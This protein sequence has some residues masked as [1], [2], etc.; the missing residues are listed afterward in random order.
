MPSANKKGGDME[1]DRRKIKILQAI[2]TDYINTGEPVGSRTI[3]KKYDL[4]ISSA[5]IRNE[6]S[7]LEEMGY[8]EQLHSSSGR[9]PSDKGYRLYVDKIMKHHDLTNEEEYIIKTKILDSALFEMDRLLRQATVLVSD[10]TRLTCIVNPPSAR[11]SSIRS[12]QLVNIDDNKMIFI[13]ITNNGIIKN[14]IIKTNSEIDYPTLTRL[15]NILNFRLRNL[16][17]DQMNLEVI[18]NLKTDLLDHEDIFNVVIPVLYESLNKADS[19]EAYAEGAQNIFNY[20]EYNDIDRAREFLTLLG[21]KDKLKELL[22]SSSSISIRIGNENYIDGAKD[23]SVITAVYSM[24]DKPLGSIGVIGPTRIHYSKIVT[25][26]DKIV[27][28]I[29]GSINHGYFD[30]R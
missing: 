23:C 29:N 27:Q 25:I 12:L 24:H 1:M 21:N 5:T 30:D 15:N 13:V 11:K 22:D 4:G 19:S 6:M 10:L 18:N 14:N 9:K 20:P 8:L 17:V 16:T 2:I 28:E 26:L 7:D 3:A